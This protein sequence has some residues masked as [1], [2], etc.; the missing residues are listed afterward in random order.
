M[1]ARTP[2]AEKEKKRTAAGIAGAML[3]VRFARL[4]RA[5]PR[6]PWVWRI[7]LLVLVLLA[8]L[9]GTGYGL[10]RGSL[11]QTRGTVRLPGLGADVVVTRD[12][13]GVP[14]IRASDALDAWR[15]LGYVEAQDRFAQMDFMR[16]VAAGTLAALVGPAAVKLDRRHARFD[17]SARAEHIYLDAPAPERA[18]LEAYTLGVNEGLEALS[19]RPWPYLLTGTRPQP[20]K[21]SDCVLVIYAMG[22]MLQNPYNPGDRA[23]ATLRSLYPRAVS[24]FLRAPDA[25]WA[26][27][28]AGSP[29]QRPP[30]PG[31]QAIDLA[32]LPPAPASA[33]P[34][35]AA[36]QA[37][38][39]TTG[40]PASAS[41][42]GGGA[43]LT[44]PQPVPGSN[45]FAVRGQLTT[46]GH[47]LLAND[48]HLRLRVPATWYR[49]RLVYPASSATG[50]GPVSLTGVF[51]PG[52]P[53]LVIG[54]NGHIAWG[55]TNSGGDW[56]DLIQVKTHPG[57]SG[58]S[59]PVY[60]TP[61]GTMTV[62]VA[63]R[64]L[65]V[66]GE[67]DQPLT[68]RKTVWGPVIGT[69]AGGALLVSHWALAQPGGVNLEFMRL[70]QARSVKQ[71]LAMA[72]HAGIPAQNF[73]V[74]DSAGDIGWTIAGRIPQRKAGCDYAIPE[75]WADGHCGWKGWLAAA[76]YP[77]IVDPTTGYLVTANNRVDEKMEARLDLGSQGFADGAR[78]HQIESDL[79]A[80]S[81]KGQI[82]AEELHRIQLDDRA[83][84][85]TRWHNLLLNVLRPSAVQFHP[86]R[87]AL[88]EAVRQWG[89]HAAVDSVGYRLVRAFRS[90][91]A[92]TVFAPI[93]R[94]LHTRDP[95]ARLPFAGQIE[96][97]LWRLLQRRP[98]NWLNPAY[99]T[100]NALLVHAADAV[101]HRFW[102]PG[103]GFSKATWGARNVVRI[104]QPLAGALGPFARWLDMPPTPLPGDTH[105]PRV[106][107]PHF[108]ASMRMVV[109]PQ[110]GAPGLFEL[111]G[112]ESGHPLSPWYGDEF[113]AWARGAPTPLA[114][115]P[116][117]ARLVFKP[118]GRGL[119]AVPRPASKGSSAQGPSAH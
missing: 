82:S 107:A 10:L 32:A 23:R 93:L 19:V 37:V 92:A 17:L 45:S 54:T 58:K 28:M 42:A 27:P 43:R 9:A 52:M 34:A 94:K 14:T 12:K 115:G 49:A 112:G 56:A 89:G 57:A 16:R 75:S 101:I 39:K 51:L 44:L 88:R 77:R 40:V 6:S 55:L 22:W 7:P 73:L 61:A 48:P 65:K 99:P 80:M 33:T 106:Q 68:V 11:P 103:S 97:P 5:R 118:W 95:G 53:A 3:R 105:M 29:S 86:R 60:A 114:P 41:A 59:P 91:V 36:S 67:A 4:W 35:R 20:W 46:S 119:R 78:A 116:A 18:R 66:R 72:A 84:F 15:V 100:W 8:I 2:P 38:P 30:V 102:R 96:G 79:D 109:S 98:H 47:A 63:H 85:L 111:P 117:K 71:A 110:P 13:H 76:Q 50:A 90:E 21:P 26:A 113:Q 74:A 104:D 24:A 64:L 81:K 69:A 1:S 25:A 87:W 70:D 83:V 62:S 31:T 108:G